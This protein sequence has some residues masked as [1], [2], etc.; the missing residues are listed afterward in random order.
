MVQLPKST[1]LSWR[2][3]IEAIDKLPLPQ[4]PSRFAKLA[5]ELA[6]R[7]DRDAATILAL[8]ASRQA[9]ELGN[10]DD[11]EVVRR[12]LLAVTPRYHIQ[13]STDAE[14]IGAWERALA[15]V[16]RPGMLA[17]EIGAG[18]GILAML[19]ARAGAD[20][21]SCENNAVLASIA[22]ETVQQNGLA[23]RVRI[24]G[25]SCDHLRVPEDLERP[26]DLLLLDLFGDTLFDFGP[27][28]IVRR[29]RRLLQ[30][31]T[32]VIPN[33]VSLEAAL[34]NLRNWHRVVPGRIA[35][36]DLSPLTQIASLRAKLE[37]DDPDL[38]LC[39]AAAPIVSATLPD[40]LPDQNGVAERVLV[41]NGGPVNGI[42]LWLRLNLTRTRVL[43]AKP[44]LAPHGFYARP[45]FFAFAEPL[46]TLQGQSCLI[47]VR[48]E[49]KSVSAALIKH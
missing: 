6:A 24:V 30:P 37:A 10:R 14:R 16:V 8:H 4:Q 35:G 33:A 11:Q 46:D 47:R 43:E 5:I 7:R 12:A 36:F 20:V 21:V 1:S 31:G 17:L 48:W 22:E 38:S 28:E 39:S 15:D 23:G 41:S 45:T 9:G 26:A 32:I 44:G 19:A 13:I 27:F 40:D 29:V 25:K 34:A 2:V 18:S 3:F 42:V 49:G